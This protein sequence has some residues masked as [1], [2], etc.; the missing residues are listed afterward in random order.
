M[1]WNLPLLA[2]FI[3]ANVVVAMYVKESGVAQLLGNLMGAACTSLW[4]E[5]RT[6]I[7]FF[8]GAGLGGDAQAMA[9]PEEK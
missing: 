9:R 4:Q 7:E 8:Y 1:T 6:I 3:V 5:R 2:V